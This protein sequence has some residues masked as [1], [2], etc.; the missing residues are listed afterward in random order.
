MV[1]STSNLLETFSVKRATRDTFYISTSTRPEV[2][3]WRTFS[4]SNVKKI[5]RKRPQIAEISCFIWNSG[6]RNRM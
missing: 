6:W 3:I 4:L 1:A 5:N 2:E